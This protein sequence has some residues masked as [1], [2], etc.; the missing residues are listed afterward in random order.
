MA[1]QKPLKQLNNG[2]FD[3]YPVTI[4]TGVLMDNGSTIDQEISNIKDMISHI[5]LN[6]IETGIFIK[7]SAEIDPSSPSD[8]KYRKIVAGK[9]D[10]GEYVMY[11]DQTPYKYDPIT[12]SYIEDI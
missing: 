10:T 8:G 5:M 9:I 4:S 6:V 11:L 2:S 12:R 3:F 1:R 7:C